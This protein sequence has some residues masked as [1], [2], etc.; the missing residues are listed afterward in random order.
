MTAVI[1]VT[2]TGTITATITAATISFTAPDTISDSANGFGIFSPWDYI[3]ISWSTAN[4]GNYIIATASAST[5]TVISLPTINEF[6]TEAAWPSITISAWVW[7]QTLQNVNYPSEP[8]VLVHPSTTD[9]WEIEAA[10]VISNDSNLQSALTWWD[11]A[12]TVDWATIDVTQLNQLWWG[13]L[14]WLDDTLAIWNTSGANDIL[15]DDTQKIQF[16]T[17]AVNHITN[18]WTNQVTQSVNRQYVVDIASSD[19]NAERVFDDASFTGQDDDFRWIINYPDRSIRFTDIAA[20]Y[21]SEIDMSWV[22]ATQTWT[23]PDATWTV[24]L[25]TD[26]PWVEWLADTLAVGNTSWANN[27]QMTGT[28]QIQFGGTTNYVANGA[29]GLIE[30]TSNKGHKFS[31]G[32]T[33]FIV[34]NTGKLQLN[35]TGGSSIIIDADATP[36]MTFNNGTASGAFDFSQLTTVA[37]SYQFPDATGTVA[38]TS[39]IPWAEDLTTTLGIGN[40]TSGQDIILTNW[41]NLQVWSATNTITEWGWNRIAYDSAAGHFFTTGNWAMLIT[42]ANGN[43]NLWSTVDPNE[44]IQL[45][46][47]AW[48][49]QIKNPGNGEAATMA[50]SN[51]TAARTYDFPDASWFVALE[52]TS[53]QIKRVAVADVATAIAAWDTLT[54]YTSIT[55]TR[56][57]TLPLANSVKVWEVYTIK[58]ESW[59]VWW[60]INITVDGN[61]IETIDWVASI[62]ITAA[63]WVI[64]VY[65]NWSAW[66]TI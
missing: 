16:G 36:G 21:T 53:Q 13:F 58:D 4:D 47:N 2:T 54:A 27:I 20:W 32:T 15:M 30:H 46:P 39:D 65:S 23:M 3:A 57:A 8:V 29:T 22:T 34:S 43:L 26:I 18:V 59:S 14:Q 42:S 66:F 1:N 33:E 40:T 17:N 37:R 12:V 60:W 7:L 50:F 10:D 35:D 55:A 6:A 52:E 31:I 63:Y 64:K 45:I 25:L 44:Q 61:G 38:L 28:Q 41:D 56:I 9:L 24:A 19:G 62:D 5:I 49:I 51:H 48:Y 11:V